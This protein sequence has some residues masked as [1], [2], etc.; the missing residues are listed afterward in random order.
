MANKI[1]CK[2]NHVPPKGNFIINNDYQQT[3][4]IDF[5]GFYDEDGILISFDE[6]EYL[7]YF[8]NIKDSHK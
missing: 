6:I 1:F 5:I 3:W 2:C 7:W 8:S 4:G